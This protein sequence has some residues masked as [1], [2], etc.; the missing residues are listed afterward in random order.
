MKERNDTEITCGSMSSVAPIPSCS[1]AELPVPM[2]PSPFSFSVATIRWSSRSPFQ[3]ANLFLRL[4]ALVFSFSSALS[5]AAPS[6]AK[7]M[8]GKSPSFYDDTK[9]LYCFIVNILTFLYAAYQLFKGI[10]D[11][12][13]RGVFISDMVSDYISFIFDQGFMSKRRPSENEVSLSV[14]NGFQ[15]KVEFIGVVKLTLESNFYLVLENT[16]YVP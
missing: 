3:A 15:V 7:T 12:A 10:C 1:P 16:V 6:P 8:I 2:T 9:L 13:H 14:A 11:I 4:L 5:L